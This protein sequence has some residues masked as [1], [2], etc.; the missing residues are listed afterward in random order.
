MNSDISAEQTE[1]WVWWCETS[2][3]VRQ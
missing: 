2:C 1:T 3:D